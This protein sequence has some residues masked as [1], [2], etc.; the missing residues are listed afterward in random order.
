MFY[1]LHSCWIVGDLWCWTRH[2]SNDYLRG[3]DLRQKVSAIMSW[4]IDQ[5]EQPNRGRG[6]RKYNKI[7][8]IKDVVHS[9]S[10]SLTE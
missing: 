10:I 2:L 1:L 5:V 4:L 3:I 9:L 7:I 6:G 8:I